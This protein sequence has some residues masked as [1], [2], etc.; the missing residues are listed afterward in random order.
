MVH[1]TFTPAAYRVQQKML[2]KE[3]G[4]IISSTQFAYRTASF[5]HTMHNAAKLLTTHNIT[6][7]DLINICLKNSTNTRFLLCLSSQS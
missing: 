4:V 2:L 3:L 7:L 6:F 5:C 1:A